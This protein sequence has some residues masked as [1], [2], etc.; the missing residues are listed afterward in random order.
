MHIATRY[1]GVK[2]C[3]NGVQGK[4]LTMLLQVILTDATTGLNCKK[5]KT[6]GNKH[7]SKTT[8][9]TISSISIKTEQGK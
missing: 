9:P 2:N 7:K 4:N 8:F 3:T 5:S 6:I 1:F